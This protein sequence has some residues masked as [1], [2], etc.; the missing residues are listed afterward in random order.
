MFLG[1]TFSHAILKT[2][3]IEDFRVQPRHLS[4]WCGHVYLP[5]A[6]MRHMNGEDDPRLTLRPPNPADVQA[7]AALHVRCWR[8]AYAHL[9]P[10]EFFD[11]LLG[12]RLIM[13]TSVLAQESLPPRLVVAERDTDLVGF[14]WAGASQGADPARELELYAIYLDAQ[15]YGSGVGQMMLDEV[16]GASP[17]QLWVAAEN[18]RARAFYTRN[19]FQPDG[20]SFIDPD[21]HDMEEVRLIR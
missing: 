8:Q 3:A 16:L 20:A 18:P 14:A 13:W 15:Q 4:H 7:L 12:S 5:S 9:L 2:P 19:G 21:A 11:D 17:A 1:G 10:T 6:T